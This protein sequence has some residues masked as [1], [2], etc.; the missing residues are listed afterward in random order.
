MSDKTPPDWKLDAGLFILRLSVGSMMLVHGIPKLNKLLSGSA[1]FA[2]PFGL[3]PQI[4]LF[5]AVGAEVGCSLLLILG[6]L[7]RLATLPLI[8]TMGVAV[9]M[10]HGADPFAKKEM[11]LLYLMPYIA[12]LL[13]GPGRYSLDHA[14]NALLGK[15]D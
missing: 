5:L 9:F 12:I 10:I 3:G 14:L 4:S 13:T 7:T 8:V 15:K 6:L 1:Q 2:D 11:A